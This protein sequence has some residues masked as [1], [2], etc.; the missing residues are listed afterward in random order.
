MH[1]RSAWFGGMLVALALVACGCAPSTVS[2]TPT[3]IVAT[4]PTATV[5]SGAPAGSLAWSQ[6]DASG[7]I[8]IW[9]ALHNGSAHLLA[10]I[11]A[12]SKQCGLVSAGLPLLSPDLR[13][14]L[15]GLGQRCDSLI[16][17]P[18][19][20]AL[21]D[22][23]SGQLSYVPLPSG[24]TVLPQVRSYGWVDNNTIFALAHDA[25]LAY[26]GTFV[27]SLGATRTILIEGLHAPLEGIAVRTTLF[28]LGV[29]PV[30]GGIESILYRYDLTTHRPFTGGIDLG[31]Y[32]SCSEC[33]IM[34]TSPG[35]DVT[36]D[37]SHV[38]Y[39]RTTSRAG[40]GR[41]SS[42]QI[43]YSRTD[44]SGGARIAQYLATD[45]MVHLRL[46]PDGAHVAITAATPSPSVVTACVTSSGAKGDPCFLTYSP[47]AMSVAAW[48]PDGRSFVAATLDASYG[49]P[50][51]STGTLIR[52]TLGTNVGQA[53]V[54]GACDPW[55]NS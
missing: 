32:A 3:A 47:D 10:T 52:Y 20:L 35:W 4:S 51:T 21:I 31:S 2:T 18:G 25:T 30:S 7:A 42:S 26:T 15:V 8:Q 24:V 41:I 46:A 19:P 50:S 14:V 39:Q 40:G 16:L 27:Y 53:L 43:I 28:Y 38:V 12:A 49:Q 6:Y 44:G 5:S 9:V 23:V 55:S 36:S 37:G 29:E 45:A 48:A 33:P 13:H 22:A 34:V 17:D 1:L 11:T 54:A